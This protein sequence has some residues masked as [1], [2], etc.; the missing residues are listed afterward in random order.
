ME[1]RFLADSMLGRLAKWLR[2][3][4]YDTHYQG[5]Y[6]EG[7]LQ[8]FIGEGRKLL[9][10]DKKTVRKYP[11]PLLILSGHVRDQLREIEST[12]YLIQ[13]KERWFSRCLIC[14]VTL[15]EANAEEALKNV[16]EY[17]YY[18]N[19]KGVHFCP[20]CGRYFWPGSH[21]ERMIRQLEGWGF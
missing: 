11:N 13:R 17:V 1:E 9:S 2:V 20:S 3:M 4:G 10:R 6:R 18:Q 16:P 7:M 12:G 21:R 5:F 14:N 8:Y 15:S 19:I